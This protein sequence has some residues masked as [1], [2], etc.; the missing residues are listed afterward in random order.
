MKL[1]FKLQVISISIILFTA[2][3]SAQI[4]NVRVS[5]VSRTDPNEVTIAVNPVNGANLTAAAN[6]NYI[7]ASNDSGKTWSEA[8]IQSSLGTAGD[9]VLT[10]DK[11]GN[12]YYGHLSRPIGGDWLDRIVVQKSTNNGL[13]WHNGAGVGYN[14]PK[15]QDKE[16]L[17][18]DMT[19]S[20][21]RNNIYMSW[22]EF[23]VYGSRDIKDSTRII[24]ARSTDSGNNWS[25]PVRISDRAGNCEDDDN[26]VEGAVPAV[27][28]D[29]EVYVS[30]G[31]WGEILFDRSFDG[32]KTFG[33]DV[34]IANQPN[35]WAYNISG[36][37]RCN[38]MPVTLCDISN[39]PHRGNVYVV[40][41]DTRNGNSDIFISKSTDKGSHWSPTARVDNDFL[42]KKDQFFP[43][44]TID[45][46]SGY[47]YVVFYDRRNY[48]DNKTDVYLAVSKDGANSFQNYKISESYF[49]PDATIFF[50]DYTCIAAQD[51]NIYPIW[52]RMDNKIMS[53]W[54]AHIKENMLVGI[55]DEGN[56]KI[57]AGYE[58]EQ[59]YPN[60]FNPSTSISYKIPKGC[61]VTLKVYDLTGK[62]LETIYDGYKEA[63]L[64]KVN[65]NASNLSS[66]RY[67]Y[68]LTA[69]NM[70]IPKMMILQ[71]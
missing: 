26:T 1:Y 70:A 44:A 54:S 29:G 17:I 19:N 58:L 25:V 49:I 65:F 13:S 7:Y 2:T 11:S 34:F 46:T 33:K 36:I 18:A 53:V 56:G 42:G 6:L 40:W 47:I 27:G 57:P 15:D 28:P 30:W 71:K 16:W 48:T 59:N 55:E 23:D 4:R 12:L 38:G 22:T 21:F 31:G 50:G 69:D 9:P 37:Y 45:Q 35:G 67:F 60:P 3:L 20:Q 68:V 51:G 43:W 41:S 10:Y 66:G 62:E 64:H 5:S 39:S 8:Y 14:H 52:M 32:G 61:K 24:L 63:G